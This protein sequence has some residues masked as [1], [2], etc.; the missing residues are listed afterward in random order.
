MEVVLDNGEM[1]GGD[2]AGSV[3]A[4]INKYDKMERRQRDY[5]LSVFP[6]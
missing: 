1:R 2:L 5:L 6:T 3:D 4:T